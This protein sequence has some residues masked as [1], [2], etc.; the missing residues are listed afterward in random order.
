M[1]PVLMPQKMFPKKKIKS[2]EKTLICVANMYELKTRA[3]QVVSS[4][5]ATEE[6]GAIMGREIESRQG[7]G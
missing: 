3:S 6:T 2:G 5:P 1:A 7:T 4:P